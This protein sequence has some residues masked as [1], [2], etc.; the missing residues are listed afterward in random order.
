MPPA[1]LARNPDQANPAQ[2]GAWPARD[3][4]FEG[5][6]AREERGGALARASRVQQ[7]ALG[8]AKRSLERR[9][10][11]LERRSRLSESLLPAPWETPRGPWRDEGVSRGPCLPPSR[12]ESVQLGESFSLSRFLGDAVRPCATGPTRPGR[13][14]CTLSISVILISHRANPQPAQLG[15]GSPAGPRFSQPGPLS[16]RCPSQLPA[17]LPVVGGC[18]DPSWPG[19]PHAP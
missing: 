9:Q 6:E 3:E 5:R 7:E 17:G 12:G 15:P 14:S 11:A 19:P 2:R 10:E 13:E 8:G 16:P 1:W 18:E 4:P